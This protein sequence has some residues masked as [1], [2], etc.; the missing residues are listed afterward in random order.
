M[1][2]DEPS[3]R[4][5][6]AL[7]GDRDAF[8]SAVARAVD[9][10]G[11]LMEGQGSAS[12]GER[13]GRSLGP[14]A[15]GRIDAERFAGLFGG[16]DTL[17]PVA[18]EQVEGAHEVLSGIHEAGDDLFRVQLPDGESLRDAVAAATAR[19]GRAF[20][21]ARTAELARSGR[22][23]AEDHGGYL[24]AFPFGMWNRREREIAPPLVVELGGRDLRPAGLCEFVDGTAKIVLVV[25][26]PAP[27]ASLVR[28]VTPAVAVVQ[29]DDADDLDALADHQ[30]PAVAALFEV[31]DRVAR[32][33]HAPGGDEDP[34]GRITIGDLPGEDDVLPVGTI[35]RRQQVEELRLLEVLAR[36]AGAAPVS[37]NG[38][39]PADAEED[40]GEP[41]DRLA[42]WLLRQSGL[43]E[44]EG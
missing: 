30:G 43:D 32:F 44:V 18:R 2:S 42:G 33:V 20:G 12:D 26:G 28:L 29:T 19:L 35:S 25:T 23:R 36:R 17:E 9:E 22:W 13:A 34:A 24:E 37:G 16:S 11:G 15:R 4:A 8:R 21:A 39:G 7:A 1:P 10:V 3:V 40:A 6:E 38:A 14:M 27:P 5:I 31:G 41:A